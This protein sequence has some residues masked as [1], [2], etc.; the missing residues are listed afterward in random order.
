MSVGFFV[1]SVVVGVVAGAV[2]GA[3]RRRRRAPTGR[4]RGPHELR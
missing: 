2:V 4:S 1:A 3:I